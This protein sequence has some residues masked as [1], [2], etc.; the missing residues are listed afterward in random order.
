METKIDLRIDSGI[1]EITLNRPEKLNALDFETFDQLVAIGDQLAQEPGVRVAVLSG[2][3]RSFSVGID[4]SAL[5]GG[6]AEILA[7]L[8]DVSVGARNF[9]QRC[10]LQWRDLPFPVIA[11]IQGHAVGGGMQLA[12]GADIRIV[13]PQAQLS[14]REVVW[15]L[16]PDMAGTVLLRGLVRDDIARDLLVTGRTVSG[17]EA[18][19]IGLATRLADDP[20]AAALHLAREIAALSP[21][22]VRAA[23][24][25]TNLS[26]AG[27]SVGTILAAEAEEQKT[28]VS[29]SSHREAL[30]AYAAKR[31]PIFTD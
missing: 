1:A 12:L 23:K 19:A 3:G 25:L 7:R 21:Q 28:L 8:N 30:A 2:R 22:A 14:I 18:L 9:F 17:I 4:L 11:A 27:A 6:E 16:I 10:A 13:A 15:G 5:A 20:R 31:P 29:G 24:R 26:A